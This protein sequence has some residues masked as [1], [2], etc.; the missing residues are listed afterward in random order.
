MAKGGNAPLKEA[1]PFL[2]RTFLPS[3]ENVLDLRLPSVGT[4][5]ITSSMWPVQA[6]IFNCP[7]WGIRA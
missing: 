5:V 7:S 6:V 2:L 3:T 4:C 1:Q